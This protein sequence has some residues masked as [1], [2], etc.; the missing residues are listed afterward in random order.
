MNAV[1]SGHAHVRPLDKGKNVK[2]PRDFSNRTGP[3]LFLCSIGDDIHVT[4]DDV[5]GIAEQKNR[6]S[7]RPPPHVAAGQESVAIEVADY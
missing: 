1:A 7:T 6:I 3:G 5:A 4:D 2:W